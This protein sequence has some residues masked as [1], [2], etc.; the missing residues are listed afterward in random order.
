MITI[1]NKDDATIVVFENITIEEQKVLD[2]TKE[3]C[4]KENT[5]MK[6]KQ[7]LYKTNS[8]FKKFKCNQLC[9]KDLNLIGDLESFQQLDDI[10][11][12]EIPNES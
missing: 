2:I 1:L 11:G 6:E 3:L 10:S 9:E 5:E 7:N 12:E 8:V 4:V